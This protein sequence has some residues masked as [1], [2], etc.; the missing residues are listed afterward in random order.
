VRRYREIAPLF[1]GIKDED[2]DVYYMFRE[3]TEAEDLELY[4]QE[5]LRYDVTELLP[6]MIGDE[7]IKTAGHFHPQREES[8]QRWPELY[9]IVGGRALFILQRSLG[10]GELGVCAVHMGPGDVMLIPGDYGHVMTNV[11]N[12]ALVSANIVGSVFASDYSEYRERR[13][14]AVKCGMADGVMFLRQNDAYSQVINIKEL[15]AMEFAREIGAEE[16]VQAVAE[17]GDLHEAF[18][19]NPEAFRFLA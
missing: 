8:G 17:V 14:A 9:Q 4:R 7:F 15:T 1:D 11:G 2:F 13:G 12:E 3:A 5:G 16:F 10:D 6:V 18:K 19:R